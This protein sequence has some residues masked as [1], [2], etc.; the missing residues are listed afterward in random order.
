MKLA[1]VG[2]GQAGSKVVDRFIEYD[3]EHGANLVL[4]QLLLTQ[5]NRICRD[6]HTFRNQNVFSSGRHES[7]VTASVQIMNLALR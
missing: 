6:L 2:V 7:R 1:M 5:Q 4:G 3:A